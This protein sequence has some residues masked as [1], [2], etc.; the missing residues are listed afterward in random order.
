MCKKPPGWL[1][2]V[3]TPKNIARVLVSIGHSPRRSAR[4]HTPVLGMSDRSVQP[5]L[6]SDLNLHSYKLQI[7]HSLSDW[8]KEVH[9]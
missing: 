1:S 6:N 9:L 7:V 5:I 3:R 4:K 2:S 8:D